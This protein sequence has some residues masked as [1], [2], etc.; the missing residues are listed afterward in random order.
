M[1]FTNISSINISH[2]FGTN[3]VFLDKKYLC[4]TESTE[5]IDQW[6]IQDLTLGGAWTL[7][8]GGGGNH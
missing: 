7:S 8:T 4:T 2:D 5:S 1:S 3:S 6:R